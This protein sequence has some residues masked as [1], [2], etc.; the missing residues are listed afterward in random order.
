MAEVEKRG[1]Q[2]TAA[3]AERTE[4]TVTEATRALP[5]SSEQTRKAVVDAGQTAR[6]AFAESVD[7]ARAEL[8]AQ[9]TSLLGG[10]EPQ[11]VLRLQPLLDKFGRTL[12]ERTRAQAD[13]LVE[14]VA[15]QFDP[16]DPASPMAQQMRALA[17]TQATYA[18][19]ATQQQKNVTD[20]LDALGAELLAWRSTK[21]ALARTAAKGLTYEE[22]THVLLYEIGAGLGDDYS[23]TGNVVGLRSRSKKGD[24]VLV[25]PGSD[26]RLVVEMTDSPRTLLVGLP[27]GGRGQPRRPG[28]AW[29]GA[30]GRTTARWADPD[31]WPSPVRD[32]LR[33]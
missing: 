4:A 21:P 6:V 3:S 28:V 17:Q 13:V 27:E 20:K 2:M 5:Q 26:A 14:K 9:V 29:A 33:P 15:K 7:N 8:V 16:A 10:E 22:Q 31:P 18:A 12:E 25:V 32:G 24:G 23:E 11:L 1:L 30:I 19:E